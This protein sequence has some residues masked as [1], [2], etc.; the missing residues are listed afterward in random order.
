[1]RSRN[2]MVVALGGTALLAG[3]SGGPQFNSLAQKFQM[4]APAKEKLAEAKSTS[5]PSDPYQAAL[6]SA[7]L[8]YADYEYSR[9]QDYTDTIFHSEKAIAAAGGRQVQPQAIGDRMLPASDVGRLTAARERLTTALAAGAP[10]IAPG[11]AARAVASFDCWMEQ[12]EENIQPDDIAACEK[13]FQQAMAELDAAMAKKPEP[14]AVLPPVVT[15]DADVL[16]AF[17]KAEI[18]PEFASE[19][20]EVAEIIKANPG[21][22]LEIQGHTDSVGSETYNQGLSER[23]AKAAVEY[24]VSKGVRADRMTAKGYGESRPVASNDT[25][26]GRALNRRVEIHTQ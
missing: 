4:M 6:R 18:R 21:K 7:Y 24:L 17:D 13:T 16:F 15:V 26:A 2:I 5:A 8:G 19:L 11:P 20:D 10:S 9:M 25:D 14:V 12:Q 23:R 22:K 1:M 3:C